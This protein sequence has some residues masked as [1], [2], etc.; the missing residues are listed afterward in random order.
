M[1]ARGTILCFACLLLVAG[2]CTE[3]EESLASIPFE[4]DFER[5]ELGGNW[6]GD[7]AWRIQDGQL[8]S[9][10]TRNRPVWLKAR[11]PDD[12]SIEFDARS[13]SPAGDIKF[14]I[15]ADGKQHASGYILIFGGWKNTIHCIARKDE[16]GAD[17][18]EAKAR[19][20]VQMG[21]TY[22]M[23]VTRQKKVIKWY[24][25][26][27]LL[28]DYFDSQPLRGDGQDRFAFNNWE[29][30]LYFD[31]LEIRPLKNKN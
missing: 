16:H 26:D 23:R 19:N 6:C 13:E 17:R 4:D 15:F 31:N 28:L 14:E 30:N 29:S 12:V 21:K 3:K 20:R 1:T 18:M 10:G 7:P 8:F 2:G 22:H 25:D 27:K 9:A 5:K 11:M 24:V